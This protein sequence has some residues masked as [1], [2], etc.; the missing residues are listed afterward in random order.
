M[1]KSMISM[2]K[3]IF[4]MIF[5]FQILGWAEISPKWVIAIGFRWKSVQID[6]KRYQ[7]VDFLGPVAKKRP[8]TAKNDQKPEKKIYRMK[9]ISA[10]QAITKMGHSHRI[11]M[12]IGVARWKNGS[13]G[14]FLRSWVERTAQNGQKSEKTF[15]KFW[16]ISKKSD[17]LRYFLI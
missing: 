6:E 3:S 15:E 5:F 12:K 16:K 9:H 10:K 14:R 1:N 11:W 8:K 7:E 17:L 4:S 13:G 2:K